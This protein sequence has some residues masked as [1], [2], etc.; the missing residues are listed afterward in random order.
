MATSKLT[1]VG[2]NKYQYVT[3]ARE[4]TTTFQLNNVLLFIGEDNSSYQLLYVSGPRVNVLAGTLDRVTVTRPDSEQLVIYNPRTWN[5]K[6]LVMS[7][8]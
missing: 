3:A 4:T 1:L 6:I 2:S 5:L 8:A 7:V